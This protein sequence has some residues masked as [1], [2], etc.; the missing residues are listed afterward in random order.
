MDRTQ[1][2]SRLRRRRKA[3]LASI[4]LHYALLAK[5]E[6][7]LQDV[8]RLL[9]AVKPSFDPSRK[10]P[11]KRRT[12]PRRAGLISRQIVKALA[13]A[14]A[15]LSVRSVLALIALPPAKSDPVM[16][17]HVHLKYLEKTGR[18][19]NVGKRGQSMWALT[20]SVNPSALTQL[21]A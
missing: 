13:K 17:V 8:D 6:S 21:C 15:P 16:R 20:R 12:G 14:N 5:R 9:L 18:V 2:I 4:E 1:A 3:L 11:P 10:Q 19:I 7:Q